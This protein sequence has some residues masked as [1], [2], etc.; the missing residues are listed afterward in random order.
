MLVKEA[1]SPEQASGRVELP[2]LSFV[3]IVKC[4]QDLVC[5]LFR[6]PAFTGKK[7]M[8]GGSKG[9]RERRGC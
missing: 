4:S 7:I 1:G 5:V 8:Q 2:G 9:E 6:A 3:A